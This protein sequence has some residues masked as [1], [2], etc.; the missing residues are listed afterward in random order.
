MFSTAK[1]IAD[2]K[3]SKIVGILPFLT[4]FVAGI[5]T[6]VA[7]ATSA[8]FLQDGWSHGLF[9]KCIVLKGKR[10]CSELSESNCHYVHSEVM[11]KCVFR[12][13]W[14]GESVRRIVCQRHRQMSIKN[15]VYFRTLE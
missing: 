10:K 2:E 5:L 9:Q 15:H 14:I 3:M 11:E 6:V 1:K 13:S 8:W 4:N 12:S 7:L